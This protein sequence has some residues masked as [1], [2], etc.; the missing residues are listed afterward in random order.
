MATAG[1]TLTGISGAT[2]DHGTVNT[3]A[4]LPFTVMGLYGQNLLGGT[5]GVDHSDP[6]PITIGS[7]F[8]RI[9]GGVAGI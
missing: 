4:T 6:A 7:S 8:H 1:S 2:L 3:T 9:S 5:T